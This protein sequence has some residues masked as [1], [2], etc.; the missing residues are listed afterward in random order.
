MNISTNGGATWA[1]TYDWSSSVGVTDVSAVVV[2]D[3]VY[4]GYTYSTT[5][6]E[7]RLRRCR[8][9]DGSSDEGYTFETVVNAG[10]GDVH[11][12]PRGLAE[13]YRSYNRLLLRHP[14]RHALVSPGRGDDLAEFT[15]ATFNAAAALDATWNPAY[16]SR[17]LFV[18]YAG[19][20]GN[21]HVQRFNGAAWRDTAIASASAVA[22]PTAISAYADN[23]ICAYEYAYAE[24]T[25]I[26]YSISYDAG[27]SRAPGTL[28]IPDGATVYSYMAPDVDAHDGHGTAVTYAAEM[29]E[30]DAVFY[31]VRWGFQP[32][33]WSDQIPF[34]DLDVVTGTETTLRRT[35]P[36]WHPAVSVTARSTSAAPASR[37][38]TS[39]AGGSWTCRR[40]GSRRASDSSRGTNPFGDRAT[41]RFTLPQAG[42]VRLEVFNVQ[43]R[44]VATLAEGPMTA[45]SHSVSLDGRGLGSGVYFCRLTAGPAQRTRRSW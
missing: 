31:Q 19:T 27:D 9:A 43:G 35:C 11:R 1:E 45:G 24:G 33:G 4:V 3:F 7:F 26:R 25:G 39:R 20:D 30:P 18:S 2:A 42:E 8:V 22:R 10:A 40:P 32:G 5:A 15:P 23:V 21:V 14:E 41:V 36:R 29:G 44:H 13:A 34:N 17:F 38:S 37:I 16:T 28:A 6:N 12:P